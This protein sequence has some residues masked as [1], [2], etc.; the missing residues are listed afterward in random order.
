MLHDFASVA[1]LAKLCWQLK[2]DS[3]PTRH[4]RPLAEKAQGHEGKN[5]RLELQQGAHRQD[6][7][8][9]LS[10]ACPGKA[11]SHDIESVLFRPKEDAWN[12][13]R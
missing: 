6:S 5:V 8:S 9:M 7:A 13:T 1:D 2:P 4:W 3:L 12:I 11:S 10:L